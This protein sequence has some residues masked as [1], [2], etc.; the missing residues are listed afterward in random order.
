MTTV[1]VLVKSV[2][3]YLLDHRLTPKLCIKYAINVAQITKYIGRSIFPNYM[4]L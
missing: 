2:K 4:K 1:T 3:S